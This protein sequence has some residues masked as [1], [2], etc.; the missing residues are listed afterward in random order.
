MFTLA[1]TI[2]VFGVILLLSLPFIWVMG[3]IAEEQ[4]VVEL[5]PVPVERDYSL[6]NWETDY[7]C[8]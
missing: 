4:E 5:I 2:N 3:K 8:K 7:D 6:Y 1:I